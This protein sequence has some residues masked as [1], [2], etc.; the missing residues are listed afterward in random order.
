M[1]PAFALVA[2]LLRRTLMLYLFTEQQIQY[3]QNYGNVF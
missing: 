3:P 2:S 1:S